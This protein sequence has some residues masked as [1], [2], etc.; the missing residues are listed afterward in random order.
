MGRETLGKK[1]GT[2]SL[3]SSSSLLPAASPAR[4]ADP[5]IPSIDVGAPFPRTQRTG[6]A[7][8]ARDAIRIQHVRAGG[9]G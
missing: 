1:A 2:L 5:T 6:A 9:A 8:V 7:P 4:A 3:F